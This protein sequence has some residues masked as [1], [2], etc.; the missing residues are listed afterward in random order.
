MVFYSAGIYVVHIMGQALNK[1]GRKKLFH[2]AYI[3]VDGKQTNI[4]KPNMLG[5]HNY[6]EE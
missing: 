2:G 6:Q 4:Y 1:I 3:L 5:S